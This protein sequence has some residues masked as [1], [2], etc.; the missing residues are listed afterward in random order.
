MGSTVA[1]KQEFDYTARNLVEGCTA[2]ECS[3]FPFRLGK[4]PWPTKKVSLVGIKKAQLTQAAL[5]QKQKIS[6]ISP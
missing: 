3:L 5:R 1:R 4:D 6:T 2:P